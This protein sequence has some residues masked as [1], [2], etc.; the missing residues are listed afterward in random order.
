MTACKPRIALDLAC[1]YLKSAPPFFD[2]HI[3]AMS[4]EGQKQTV[5]SVAS[6]KMEGQL[7]DR[8]KELQEKRAAGLMAEISELKKEKSLAISQVK[9]MDNIV[10]DIRKE[11]A[12]M[13]KK[14]R[15]FVNSIQAFERSLLEEKLINE[16]LKKKCQLLDKKNKE[17]AR[18]FE[19]QQLSVLSPLRE[20]TTSDRSHSLTDFARINRLENTVLTAILPRK[21]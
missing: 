10:A 19:T 14:E 4:E 9:K 6:L 20:L 15:N 11:N 18:K 3:A 8:I 5:S 13:K 17:L 2:Q 16:N 12:L 1:K 21:H 7:R